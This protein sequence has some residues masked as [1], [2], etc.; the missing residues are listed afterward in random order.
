MS[1]PNYKIVG[2][3]GAGSLIVE[4]LFCEIGV[5][6]EIIFIDSTDVSLDNLNEIH[7][8]GRIPILICS[9][10]SFIFETLAIVNHITNR[11]NKLAPKRATSLFDRYNQFLS[12]MA[13]SIY[14][15][16]HRQHHSHYYIGQESFENLRSRAHEEQLAI[17]DY[18]EKE[19][20]PFICGNVLTA[21]DFY[22]FMLMRWD[23]HKDILFDGRPELRSF[24]EIMRKKPSVA[25]VLKNQPKRKIKI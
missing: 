3:S 9:D 18:I 2:R 17:Y 1:Q 22:L 12:L 16:Y 6:Y 11:F 10:Q 19:L 15:A 7:P 4:F 20:A 25:K 21:A 24:F 23:L 5:N 13:T 8:L 14:P